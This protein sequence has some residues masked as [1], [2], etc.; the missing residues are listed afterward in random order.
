[1]I[2]IG[3]TC[4][5]IGLYSHFTS[6]VQK[7]PPPIRQALRKALYYSQSGKDITLAIQYFREALDLA[8][9]SDEMDR[10]GAPLTG[11]MIQLGTIYE[12][13]GRLPE[14]REVLTQA[15][16]HLLRLEN[17]K[18]VFDSDL[19]SF[20]FQTQRKVVGIAQKLGDI[21]ERLHQD[22]DAEKW[23]TWS[24]EHLLRISSRPVSEY[25]D[26]DQVVFDQEH[27]P[28]WL[29]KSEVGAALESLGS[30]YAS[31]KQYSYAIPLYLRA[32]SLAGLQSCQS[33]V[34]MNNLS[35]AYAGI[36]QFE[37]A[38][39]WAQK[40]LDLAQNPNT[41]K[42]NKDGEVC[43][44]TCGVLYY[45]MGMLFEQTKDT[46]KATT[47]YEQARKHGR[48]HKLLPCI[49][50]AD[51]ALRRIAQEKQALASLE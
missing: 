48:E 6:D 9:K 26:S 46:E 30:F 31:R 14:A 44:E 41:R 45:N 12:S 19:E 34:L 1:M 23:Y 38:K 50:E 28:E 25:G 18:N 39:Q 27:M 47:F 10:D 35:E 24:V 49:K 29:T 43:D 15:L 8:L 3:F 5:G 20:P 22:E 37:D 21:A 4:L 32:L 7:Y 42:I 33:A 13:L 36:S 2:G 17:M 11:I 40:G 16:C 51:R